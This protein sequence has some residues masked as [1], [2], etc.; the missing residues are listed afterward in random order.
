[1]AAPIGLLQARTVHQREVPYVRRFSYRLLFL[2][3]DVDQATQAR[4]LAR[5][6]AVD[7][8]GLF[9]W[10][11]RDHGDGTA[12]LRAWAMARFAEAGVTEAAGRLRLIALP[13]VLGYGFRPISVWIGHDAEGT[14][15][16]V[17]YE[18]S[19]TFGER[20]SYVARLPGEG[21]NLSSAQHESD[22]AFH[23]SPFFDVTG[24]YRFTLHLSEM[25][26]SLLVENYVDGQRTHIASLVG[27]T[28]PLTD[29][30]LLAA[31]VR[32][33]FMAHGVTAGIHW[34]AL[35]IWLKGAGYRDKPVPPDRPSTQALAV[36]PSA[37]AIN[38]ARGK[39]RKRLENSRSVRVQESVDV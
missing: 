15:V 11:A 16:G 1:M 32:M 28:A 37:T 27:R 30:A 34:E 21:I 8:G 24:Q 9:A 3:I 14:P 31:L 12:P 7:R 4:G 5:C 36:D 39:P 38:P 22:K 35:W 29:G 10:R 26:F 23:V 20:H 2:D 18:V 17:I 33:P 6:F 25:R 19:N 13:R